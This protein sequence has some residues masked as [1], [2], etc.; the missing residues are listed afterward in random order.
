MK[1]RD[2]AIYG[3]GYF[4]DNTSESFNQLTGNQQYH[5]VNMFMAHEYPSLHTSANVL[6]LLEVVRMEE[7]VRLSQ[8]ELLALLRKSTVQLPEQATVLSA[9]FN[10]PIIVT[11][12]NLALNVSVAK[13]VP[14]SK[15]E[16]KASGGAS[17][18]ASAKD[19][20]TAL[21]AVT[22]AIASPTAS[23]PLSSLHLSSTAI[24]EARQNTN[25]QVELSDQVDKAAKKCCCDRARQMCTLL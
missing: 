24:G 22:Q 18:T 6:Q 19:E 21:L 11:P 5:A 23:L 4:Y 13:N 17:P 7:N 2:S 1:T 3:T 10:T 14:D 8:G 16:G 15:E 12:V 9:T 25:S 20:E